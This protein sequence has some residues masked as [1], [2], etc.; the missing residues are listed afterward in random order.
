MPWG[1]SLTPAHANSSVTVPSWLASS[2]KGSSSHQLL[3]PATSTT[4]EELT[5]KPACCWGCHADYLTFH[6]TKR[7]ENAKTLEK[8][9]KGALDQR[10]KGEQFLQR[11]RTLQEALLPYP[12]LDALLAGASSALCCHSP[13]PA[14]APGLDTKI[15]LLKRITN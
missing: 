11:L 4:L 8:E 12:C 14:Q 3:H 15:F 1:A 13:C 5:C 2:A 7:N 9:E 6:I 10:D